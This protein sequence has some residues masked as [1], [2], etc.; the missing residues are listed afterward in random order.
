MDILEFKEVFQLK[1]GQL[2]LEKYGSSVY[3]WVKNIYYI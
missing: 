2:H 1:F 3:A